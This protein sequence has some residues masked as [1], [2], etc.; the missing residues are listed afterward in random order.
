MSGTWR[1][2]YER[3]HRGIYMYN[4]CNIYMYYI[5]YYIYIYYIYLYIQYIL[6]IYYIYIYIYIYLLQSRC[7]NNVRYISKLLKTHFFAMQIFRSHFGS[8]F[9][10]R[11]IYDYI[12]ICNQMFFTRH[13]LHFFLCIVVWSLK[14]NT[15]QGSYLCNIVPR[16]SSPGTKLHRK[17]LK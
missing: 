13:W 4:M 11:Y 6:Y 7:N 1:H 14:D 5:I 8:F 9:C 15:A 17:K 16:V 2:T 10:A 3:E 12:Y